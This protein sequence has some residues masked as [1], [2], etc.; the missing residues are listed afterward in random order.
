MDVI[1]LLKSDLVAASLRFV[2]FMYEHQNSDCFVRKFVMEPV[3]METSAYLS[4]SS[5]C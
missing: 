4:S 1:D 5:R 3:E 2:P